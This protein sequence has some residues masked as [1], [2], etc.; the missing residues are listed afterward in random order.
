[1]LSYEIQK[2]IYA[3]LKASTE[4][5]PLI[6]DVCDNVPLQG[7]SQDDTKFP[8]VKIGDDSYIDS[9]TNCST[10]FDGSLQIR[11][12]TRSGGGSK[13]LKTIQKAIYNALNRA[14]LTVDNAQFIGL[15]WTDNPTTFTEPDGLTQTG[16]MN[17][18]I[19]V[20]NL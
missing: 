12:Y 10:G 19:L 7:E 18:R 13:Q 1:M 8:F 16:I 11:A 15:T 17:F 9:S 3:A 14:N 5:T 2:A 4:L 20:D 6:V